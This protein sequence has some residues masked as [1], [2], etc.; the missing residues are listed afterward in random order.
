MK[1]V[2]LIPPDLKTAVM[3]PTRG[4]GLPN[5]KPQCQQLLSTDTA[6]KQPAHAGWMILY[7]ITS[8]LS[9]SPFLSP[10]HIIRPQ[11]FISIRSINWNCKEYCSRGTGKA[12]HP[13][14]LQSPNW[15][16][17]RNPRQRGDSPEPFPREP[18]S[19]EFPLPTTQDECKKEYQ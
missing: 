7:Q 6:V 2:A 18:T 14:C 15:R 16:N 10:N 17:F 9:A 12:L 1:R 19:I 13:L 11:N 3:P 5:R 8:Q 4:C